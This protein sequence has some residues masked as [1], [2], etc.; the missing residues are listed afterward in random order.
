MGGPGRNREPPHIRTGGSSRKHREGVRNRDTTSCYAGSTRSAYL[1]RSG[2]A[3]EFEREGRAIEATLARGQAAR[4]A[5]HRAALIESLTAMRSDAELALH[6]AI[7]EANQDGCSW[8]LL[9]KFTDMSWQTLHRRYRGR[10]T[11][12]RPPPEKDTWLRS[13]HRPKR[14]VTVSVG[15]E[16]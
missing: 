16:W 14:V 5:P 7:Y 12:M 9:A 4:L 8:R 15:D 6:Q 1:S 3:D 13:R 10:P 2:A 11:R